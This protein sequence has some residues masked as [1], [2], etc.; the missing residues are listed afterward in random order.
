[1]GRVQVGKPLKILSSGGTCLNPAVS[2]GLV[3]YFSIFSQKKTMT[4]PRSGNQALEAGSETKRR[5][6]DGAP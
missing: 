2:S 4:P 1:M 6:M 3:F 5:S